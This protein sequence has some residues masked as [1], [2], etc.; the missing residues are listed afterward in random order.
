MT[1]ADILDKMLIWLMG[2]D[3][4]TAD[5][6]APNGG[7]NVTGNSDQ[8]DLDRIGRA[9]LLD[10][11]AEDLLQHNGGDTWNLDHRRCRCEPLHME[12]LARSRTGLSIG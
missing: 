10:Q 9:W 2:R 8:R 4:P 1:R 11:R 5:L 6:T 12:H 3:H 7:E